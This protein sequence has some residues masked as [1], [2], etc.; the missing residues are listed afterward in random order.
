MAVIF[1]HRSPDESPGH[2]FRVSGALFP[3]AVVGEGS[4]TQSGKPGV[5][6]IRMV[7]PMPSCRR[8]PSAAELSRYHSA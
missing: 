4:A 1:S 6:E 7:S 2:A 8:M 5:S 3:L